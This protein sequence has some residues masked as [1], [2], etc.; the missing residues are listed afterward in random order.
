MTDFGTDFSTYWSADGVADLDPTFAPI[1]GP[2]AIAEVIARRLSTPRGSLRRNPNFGFD[3]RNY[4]SIKLTGARKIA[5]RGGIREQCL[6]D[7]RVLAV[8]IGLDSNAAT[9]ALTLTLLLDTS[10][11]PFELVLLVTKL[12]VEILDGPAL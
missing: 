11:G 12:T 9:G 7:E 8:S 2:R 1:S 10:E 3:V 6:A 4:S 5:L